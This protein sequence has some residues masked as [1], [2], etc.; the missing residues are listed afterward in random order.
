M[1]N[2]IFGLFLTFL[3]Y[4]LGLKISEKVGSGLLNPLL[5]A[6]II[7][8]SVLKAFKIDYSDY[9][10][11]ASMI[12]FMIMP[13][14]VALAIPFYKNFDIFLEYKFAIIAGSFVG[15]LTALISIIAF[16]KLFNLK[17]TV[18][19]SIL[20]KSITT[21]IALPLAEEYGGIGSISSFA[22]TITGLTG[23]IIC[24]DLFK[25]LKMHGDIPK[26]AS[27]GTSAHAI[28][29]SKALGISETAG[30]I[31]GLCIVLTGFITVILFPF[32]IKFI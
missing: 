21:A 16:G 22:I 23:V 28:G 15:S 31:G 5:I 10:I 20:P 24:E 12:Q 13:A 7:S 29:T 18:L 25:I 27:L 11:G 14:T 32:A 2:P 19:I 8:I 1:N 4:Y 9:M 17:E 6:I 30:A 3:A 26:G